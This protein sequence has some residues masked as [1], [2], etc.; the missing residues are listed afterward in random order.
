MLTDLERL[1]EF[2]RHAL[3]T[4]PLLVQPIPEA[5]VRLTITD[6]KIPETA[7]PH[8]AD[9]IV[10]N[11]AGDDWQLR[12]THADQVDEFL[13]WRLEWESSHTIGPITLVRGVHDELW[14]EGLYDDA[15][16]DVGGRLAFEAGA[17]ARYVSP[18]ELERFRR[19][20]ASYVSGLRAASEM[21]VALIDASPNVQ[22]TGLLD[23]WSPAE[24]PAEVAS[25]GSAIIG[26]VGSELTLRFADDDRQ[27]I[28]DIQSCEVGIDGA[29][30]TDGDGERHVLDDDATDAVCSVVPHATSW[31]VRRV[32]EVL[33]WAD[34]VA[35]LELAAQEATL[36]QQ[37]VKVRL[38]DDRYIALSQVV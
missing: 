36:S 33:V 20:V 2:R 7:P 23:A 38:G 1:I 8:L 31:R 21:A 19:A 26:F 35:A 24:M 37:Q 12:R 28:K 27:T 22:R 18:M 15:L 29:V 11:D 17:S 4:D 14:T 5:V 6:E 30:V 3:R 10:L 34:L 13:E 16:A 9:A 25:R 32:P